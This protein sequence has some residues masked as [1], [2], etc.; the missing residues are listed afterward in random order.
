[1]N[2]DDALADFDARSRAL[3]A[4]HAD[5][6]RPRNHHGELALL[7]AGGV[8]L[9]VGVVAGDGG[10]A[11]VASPRRAYAAY[12]QAETERHYPRAGR[13]LAPVF[14]A[15]D[16][17]LAAARIDTAVT[18]NQWLLSTN[19]QPPLR[20]QL[21]D[22]WLQAARERW[23]RRAVWWRSLNEGEHGDWIAALRERGFVALA[24]RQVWLVDD[25]AVAAR[26]H[27]DLRRDLKR[28]HDGRYP[29]QREGF[30]AAD[31]A[32]AAELYALLYRD[33]YSRFNPD[34]D[35]TFLQRWHAAGLLEL[36][37]GRGDDGRLAWI[38]GIFLLGGVA[39][40]PLVGYDTARPQ[41]EAL[42][43]RLTAAVFARAIERGE[44]LNLS[45][46]VGPFKRTRGGRPAI[47]YSLVDARAAPRRTRAAIAALAAATTRLAAPWMRRAGL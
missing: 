20:P 7:E 2:D 35:A 47:E 14:A 45:A 9:P 26:R 34:Y 11:W 12:A 13:L 36:Q 23:P 33:K 38:A 4:I 24:S 5:G 27:A 19:L 40:T 22:A 30:A 18:L 6:V 39:T 46:G 31:F 3:V 29:P 21:L 37:G 16:A 1:M 17:A 44:R 28:L 8:A 41:R 15:L 43:R 32:R 10:E 25:P 42:Y